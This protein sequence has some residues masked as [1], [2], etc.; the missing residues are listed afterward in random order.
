MY[1][2]GGGWGFVGWV[3]CSLSKVC[4]VGVEGG[5]LWVGLG[6]VYQKCVW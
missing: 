6:V 1:G 3:R 2:R 4:M 5:V